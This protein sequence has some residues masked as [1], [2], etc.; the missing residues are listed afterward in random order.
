MPLASI[1]TCIFGTANGPLP[2][3]PAFIDCGAPNTLRLTLT[4]YREWAKRFAAGLIKAGLR[5]G[6]P[7][8]LHSKNN[9]FTPVVIMGIVM[10]G[11]VATAANPALVARE[12][13]YQLRDSGARFL[14]TAS[15][16]VDCAGQAASVAGLDPSQIFIFDH[17]PLTDRK[18]SKSSYQHWSQLITDRAAG[19]LFRWEEF[20]T[21][22]HAHRT[23]LLIYSSGTTGLPKGVEATHRNL[24]ANICQFIHLQTLDPRFRQLDESGRARTLCALPMYHGLGLILYSMISPKRHLPVYIMERFDRKKMVESIQRFKITELLLVPPILTWLAKSPLVRSG[25]FR[26]LE[27]AESTLWGGTFEC[28]GQRRIRIALEE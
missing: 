4:E 12:L 9:I 24:V 3:L 19:A 18:P 27:R 11:G 10:A 28:W 17:T 5:D 13:A 1:P 2:D 8:L 14:L 7:V 20:S 6:D 23:A 15:D 26:S 22:A 21:K 25:V 16:L